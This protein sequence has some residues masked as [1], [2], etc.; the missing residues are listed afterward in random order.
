MS[1]YVIEFME[2]GTKAR[3]AI[4]L[5][6]SITTAL[7]GQS[8]PQFFLTTGE[9]YV[10]KGF[11]EQPFTKVFILPHCQRVGYR[12]IVESTGEGLVLVDKE[13]YPPNDIT[14]EEFAKLRAERRVQ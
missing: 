9:I 14:D 11:E 6:Y 12:H 2:Q 8:A 1:E 13:T 3:E 4:R 7:F 5:V 10:K